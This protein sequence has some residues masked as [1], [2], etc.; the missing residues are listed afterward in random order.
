L[1]QELPSAVIV[2]VVLIAVVI[3]AVMAS[4]MTIASGIAVFVVFPVLVTIAS[5]V[6]VAIIGV[7]IGKIKAKSPV[8]AEKVAPR[9]HPTGS[10][11]SGSFVAGLGRRL[12]G[13][14]GCAQKY[15]HQYR[16]EAG[17]FSARA[18]HDSS[19]AVLFRS[20]PG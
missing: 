10:V 19:F 7:P 4:A 14:Q 9:L 1:E 6:V 11:L 15:S 2:V 13:E 12:G 18:F 17:R 8:S 20:M 5:V 3:T 16:H